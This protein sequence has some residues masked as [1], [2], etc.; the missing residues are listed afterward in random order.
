MRAVLLHPKGLN[1]PECIANPAKSKVAK[2]LTKRFLK[3]IPEKGKVRIAR[4]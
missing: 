3:E 4:I 1:A 2:R